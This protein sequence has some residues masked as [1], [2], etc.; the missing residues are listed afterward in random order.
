MRAKHL[1]MAFFLTMLSGCED[2]PAPGLIACPDFELEDGT[3]AF[4][5]V[6]PVLERRCGTLDCHGDYARPLR[7]M[8]QNGLRL[9]SDEELTDP[10]LILDN[11]TYAGGKQTSPEEL[12]ANRRSVCGLEPE[13]TSV[14]VRT[15][16][17]GATRSLM[18]LRKPLGEDSNF[19][20]HKGGVLF[21][22]GGEGEVC[23][24]CWLTGNA[25][26]EQ[27]ANVEEDC[28]T[29]VNDFL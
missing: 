6:S 21:R 12:D 2:I 11:M 7:I 14:V 15:Q 28:S 27:C 17:F 29:A 22:P 9:L 5:I 3:D 16:D 10:Q 18:L 13:R 19:E 8:G 26:P 24:A 23:V 25:D 4:V 1:V 20:K